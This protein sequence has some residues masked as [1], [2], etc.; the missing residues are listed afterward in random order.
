MMLHHRTH[1][2]LKKKELDINHI[3]IIPGAKGSL[4]P[5]WSRNR[6]PVFYS[7]PPAAHF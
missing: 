2:C 4:R 5:I 7:R 3:V 6:S 1:P